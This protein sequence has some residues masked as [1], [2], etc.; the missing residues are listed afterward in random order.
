MDVKKLA[1]S[2]H[3]LERTVLPLVRRMHGPDA[4][5]KAAKLSETEVLRA[6]QWLQNKGLVRVDVREGD[7]VVLDKNGERYRKTGLPERRFLVALQDG[8]LPLSKLPQK[9]GLS[10]DEANVCLG[11]LRGKS[12]I[13]LTKEKELSVA[14]TEQGRRMLASEFAEEAFLQRAFP[15]QVD[16]LAPDERQTLDALRKRKEII[17]IEHVRERSATLTPMGETLL[18]QGIGVGNIIDTLTPELLRTGGWKGKGFRRYDVRASVPRITGGRRHFVEEAI[19][20]I[21]KIWLELGFVEMNGPLCQTALWNLDALFVPQDHPARDMQDT[22]FV[23]AKGSLPDVAKRIKAVHMRGGTTGST[24]WGGDWRE[25][26]A[27]QTLLRTHTT[28]LSARMIA[29]L[30]ESDLP[31]KFFSV[32]RVFRNEA[33]D[34]KHLFEF[35]QVEGIVVDPDANMRHLIGYLR[36]F[37]RKMGFDDI[38]V[39]P[40]YFPFTEPSVEVEVFHPVRKQWVEL[41]GAGIFRPEVVV[42]LL[43]KDVPVLAWGQGLERIIAEYYKLQDLRDVYRNDVEQLRTIKAWVK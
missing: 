17:R 19:S 15:Q 5:Q 4:L 2:L 12:A 40:S 14:L 16:A 30:K 9:A 11:V 36:E 10:K 31:T 22:F 35:H 29:T 33:L 3:P 43:G 42:P 39:K 34:W 6:L 8:S 38:R 32:G 37:Y 20:H 26:I 24:G 41:G 13:L 21:R 28:A 27:S 7:V 1:E 18:Q 25:D 23:D